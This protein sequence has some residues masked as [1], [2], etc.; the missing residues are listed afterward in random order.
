LKSSLVEESEI[1]IIDKKSR[2]KISL[3]FLVNNDASWL[4][5]YLCETCP[6]VLRRVSNSKTHVEN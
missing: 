4:K 2:K 6:E 1:V 5:E 3:F